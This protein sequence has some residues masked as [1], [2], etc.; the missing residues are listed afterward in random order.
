MNYSEFFNK[1]GFFPRGGSWGTILLYPTPHCNVGCGYCF[2][3]PV[4]KEQYYKENMIRSL[5]DIM[6]FVQ[7]NEQK[8]IILH[9]GEVLHLPLEDF[10]FFIKGIKKFQRNPAIQT[11]LYGLTEEHIKII[12]ENDVSIGVS[13]DGPPELNILRGPRNPKLNKE[14]Q[15]EI[16]ENLEKLKAA[17]IVPGT[18][19]ILSKANAGS[20]QKM[21]KLIEWSR[22]NTCGGRF[23]PMFYPFWKKE[24]S[25]LSKYVLNPH[26]MANVFL[27][28][29]EAS[30]KYRDFR[31]AFVTEMINNLLG[32]GLA[33]CSYSRC[34]YL[35]T[36][37]LTIMPNGTFA[38]C[39]RC[40]Q[41]G[42]YNISSNKREETRSFMLEQ[43]PMEDGGCG[44]CRY[45][46]IC[47]GNCPGEG[48]NKDYRNKSCFCEAYYKTYEKL[49]GVLRQLHP[50]IKLAID[51]PN[52]YHNYYK[53]GKVLN[54][55]LIDKRYH[56]SSPKDQ[57]QFR[58]PKHLIDGLSPQELEAFCIKNNI[59]HIDQSD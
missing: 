51:V 15:Q 21:D 50:D 7:P 44:N 35:T 2:E 19:A 26:E 53:Q 3:I 12:K 9:G 39:D 10:E 16:I 47:G 43:I 25:E 14:Y 45:F 23:N 56:Q 30:F 59:E 32:N 18:I 33:S 34:D 54:F 1:Y 58:V 17:K 20:I 42:Y 27:Y 29:T 8:K 31:P 22:K 11:S 48:I 5:E 28:L 13:I 57:Q 55:N 36:T 49:E 6:S 41:D 52:F 4:E 46:S 40:F 24:K 38:R 37:C